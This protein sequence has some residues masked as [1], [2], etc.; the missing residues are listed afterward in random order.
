MTRERF[1][2]TAAFLV[3]AVAVAA[4]G[5]PASAGGREAVPFRIAVEL[6]ASGATLTAEQGVRWKSASWT[7]GEERPCRFYVDPSGVAG[8]LD[9]GSA[10]GFALSLDLSK[11]SAD[12]ERRADLRSVRGTAWKELAYWCSGSNPCRFVLDERGVHGVPAGQ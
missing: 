9:E 7:C 6:N 12:S 5:Q 4:L 11:A 2:F 10:E 3:G 8:R 1:T